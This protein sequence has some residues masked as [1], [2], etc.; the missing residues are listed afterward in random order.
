MKL[1]GLLAGVVSWVR[2]WVWPR[3]GLSTAW[4]GRCLCPPFVD[5]IANVLGTSSC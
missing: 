3:W 4:T 2:S 1:G 5:G